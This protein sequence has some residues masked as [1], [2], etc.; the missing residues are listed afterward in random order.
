MLIYKDKVS[1]EIERM[2]LE[3]Y[4]NNSD[5]VYRQE[6]KE[7]R[8]NLITC[9]ESHV[10]FLIIFFNRLKHFQKLLIL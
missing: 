9:F 6:V 1:T 4:E 2:L 8:N 5:E 3:I 7:Q 10:I